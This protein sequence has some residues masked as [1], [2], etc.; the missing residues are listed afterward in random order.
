[1]PL[2]CVKR[3][4]KWVLA[5]P[6]GEVKGT[7]SSRAACNRQVQ[8]IEANKNKDVK[9]IKFD[10]VVGV[11]FDSSSV[12]GIQKGDKVNITI[13]S[14]GG[15]HIEALKM[16]NV[17]QKSEADIT[18]VI[19]SHA[20]SAGFTLALAGNRIHMHE[21]ALILIHPV[22]AT[23]EGPQSS[24]ELRI[25]ADM[26]E[27]AQQTLLVTL[28]A[29]T[30]LG[31]NRLN[32]MIKNTTTL[33][34]KEALEGGL[35]DKIVP[36]RTRK[37]N[38]TSLSGFIENLPDRIVAHVRSFDE[39][40]IERD[41]TMPL[42]DVAN[43]LQLDVANV[44]DDDTAIETVLVNAFAKQKEEIAKLKNEITTLKDVTPATKVVVPPMVINMASRFRMQEIDNLLKEGIATKATADQMKLN[45]ADPAK[46]SSCLDAEGN[47]TD[48][49]ES[50]ITTLRNNGPVLSLN[51]TRVLE[52]PHQEFKD[53]DGKP[54]KEED[55]LSNMMDEKAKQLV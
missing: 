11:D 21:N 18:T 42:K 17:L 20:F 34:A 50:L 27:K 49:F 7:H 15:S 54:V 19:E 51:G 37:V 29:R 38:L 33:T 44:A 32:E 35:I 14:P 26:T 48:N 53:K 23:P 30:S 45:Y 36:L 28:Q 6:D 47:E 39:S 16:L 13:N 46:L 9:N 12:N 3:G 43:K 31:E 8:A 5:G 55:M 41:A 1:M 24:D 25:L 4:N 10:G 52:N 2:A 22:A 40:F